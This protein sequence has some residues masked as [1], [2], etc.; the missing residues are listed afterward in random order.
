MTKQELA[1]IVCE[2]YEQG[3]KDTILIFKELVDGA[4]QRINILAKPMIEKF[5]KSME[6]K[7]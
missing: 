5:I 4:Q 6:S 1:K 2:A 3:C 7:S